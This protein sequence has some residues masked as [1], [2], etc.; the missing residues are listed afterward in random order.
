MTWNVTTRILKK[1]A[2]Y[3]KTLTPNAVYSM[4]LRS[5]D[6]M[7]TFSEWAWLQIPVFDLTELGMGLLYSILP[8]EFE[9]VTIDFTWEKPSLE[10]I[11]QGIWANFEPVDFTAM[12]VWFTDFREYVIANFKEQF[13]TELL[14]GILPKAI[15][16]VTP[17]GRG[18]YDPIV[19]REFLRATFWKL[20]LLRSPDISW[21]KEMEL[22]AE[23]IRMIG[24][25][26]EHIFNR[27]MMMMSAQT[28]AFVLGLS[29]LGRSRLT[30]TEDGWGVVPVLTYAGKLRYL[31]FKTLDHLQMGFVLGM[32]PLGYGLLL[33]EESI[34]K[35]PDGKKNPPVVQM[36]MNKVRGIVNRTTGFVWAYTNYCKPDEMT[37]YHRNQRVA[38][39]DILQIQK[40]FVENWTAQR[41]PKEEQN[42]VRVRQY[43]NA[44][45]Q[46]VSWRAKRHSWGF[47]AW[48]AMSDE[49]FKGW[50]IK[51]WAGQG[52]NTETLEKLYEEAVVWLKTLQREK[53]EVGKKL[54]EIRR[55][56]AKL[57]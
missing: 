46:L 19:A 53:L 29:V 30:E 5:L 42:P 36:V 39:Y 14:L 35:L 55:R 10:E 50:W 7:P 49:E 52:L 3:Q 13:Q 28:N 4:Y 33:P 37:D 11:S 48:K 17:Y 47:N 26:S 43:Q 45:L 54:K 38:Q 1:K 56:L 34:Y 21:M 25:T 18:V 8:M 6:I 41:I 44:M 51:H 9:P 24:V 57:L 16:G 32:T 40:E 2:Y 27:L 23:Y 22:I 31:Y 12:Y 15:Y 20:R